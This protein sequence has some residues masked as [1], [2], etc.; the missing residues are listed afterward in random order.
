[1]DSHVCI[2]LCINEL[3]Y[4]MLETRK[5]NHLVSLCLFTIGCALSKDI[6]LIV[7]AVIDTYFNP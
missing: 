1:M 2:T 3:N 5:Q 7:K 6:A 4:M